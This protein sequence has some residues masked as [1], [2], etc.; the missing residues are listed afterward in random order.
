MVCGPSIDQIDGDL[1]WFVIVPNQSI[2]IGFGKEYDFLESIQ[3]F[4]IDDP[5]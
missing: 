2:E 3:D 4:N 5:A 1:S